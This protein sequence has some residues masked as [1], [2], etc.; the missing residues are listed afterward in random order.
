MPSPNILGMLLCGA[1]KFKITSF[2]SDSSSKRPSCLA[3]KLR[4]SSNRRL[5]LWLLSGYFQASRGFVCYL[6]IHVVKMRRSL[7]FWNETNGD[8]NNLN[9]DARFEWFIVL[10]ELRIVTYSDGRTEPSRRLHRGDSERCM[11]HC[12]THLNVASTSCIIAFTRSTVSRLFINPVELLR[13]SD[14]QPTAEA[15]NRPV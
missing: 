2:P 3:L 12:S 1:G 5:G 8:R 9:R 4:Q 6:E 10:L 13:S 11:Y 15:I 7:L 14:S